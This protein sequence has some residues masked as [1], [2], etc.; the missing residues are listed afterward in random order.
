ME[1]F[2][3]FSDAFGYPVSFIID[4]RVSHEGEDNEDVTFVV[5]AKDTK[6]CSKALE[7]LLMLIAD[8]AKTG[9]VH[10]V[11]V[12]GNEN[13]ST[14]GLPEIQLRSKV[15]QELLSL[16]GTTLAFH[17]CNVGHD[18][19]HE[20]HPLQGYHQ[21]LGLYSPWGRKA[22]FGCGHSGYYKDSFKL[23]IKLI[24]LNQGDL[25]PLKHAI[26]AAQAGGRLG[27]LPHSWWH[28]PHS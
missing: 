26:L 2:N 17:K 9:L 13:D 14:F 28:C 25:L 24:L 23:P 6:C 4:A 15:L 11:A 7:P 10:K 27:A 1:I 8:A 22:F 12:S 16:D 3:G 18:L 5:A 20:L 19:Q 21:I